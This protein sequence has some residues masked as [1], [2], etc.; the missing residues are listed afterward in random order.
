MAPRAAWRAEDTIEVFDIGKAKIGIAICRDSFF[1]EMT[2]T[3]YS[4]GA[5][6][7]LMPFGNTTCLVAN[8]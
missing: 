6:I 7:V 1:D 8:T 3:L 5:E 2:S 4:K